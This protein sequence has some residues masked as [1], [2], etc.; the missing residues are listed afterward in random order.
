MPHERNS[1]LI[2]D[3]CNAIY[4]DMAIAAYA[5]ALYFCPVKTELCGYS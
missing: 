5:G 1:L 4:Q 2:G 3:D